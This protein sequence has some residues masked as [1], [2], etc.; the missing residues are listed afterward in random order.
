[1]VVVWL[2]RPFLIIIDPDRF[3]FAS[4]VRQ[5]T[6][7]ITF[8]FHTKSLSIDTGPEYNAKSVAETTTRSNWVTAA[9]VV[10][11]QKYAA[12]WDVFTGSRGQYNII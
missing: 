9:A 10:E 7:F 4:L 3:G 12:D 8:L 6:A 11:G 2:R 5:R 1:M